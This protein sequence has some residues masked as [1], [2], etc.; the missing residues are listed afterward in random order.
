MLTPSLEQLGI[1]SSVS[2]S[3]SRQSEKQYSAVSVTI[4]M[5]GQEDVPDCKT[6]YISEIPRS[7]S[8]VHSEVVSEL[9]SV[10]TSD[11]SVVPLSQ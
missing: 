8:V 4:V 7:S 3:R 2:D 10:M 9:E 6:E 1:E 5:S 11:V